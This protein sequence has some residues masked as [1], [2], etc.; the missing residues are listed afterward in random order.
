ML[1]NSLLDAKISGIRCQ[2]IQCGQSEVIFLQFTIN[3]VKRGTMTIFI[4]ADEHHEHHQESVNGLAILNSL[5]QCEYD[6]TVCFAGKTFP[7][8]GLYQEF[9]VVRV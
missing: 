1:I 2:S 8:C 3:S 5:G 7:I 6:V 4:Q 9:R